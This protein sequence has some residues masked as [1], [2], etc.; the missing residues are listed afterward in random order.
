[1]DDLSLIKL[2][3]GLLLAGFAFGTSI[4]RYVLSVLIAIVCGWA[5][6]VALSEQSFVAATAFGVWTLVGLYGATVFEK[7]I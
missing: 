1:M 5:G 7:K 4:V 3:A 2:A 6:I